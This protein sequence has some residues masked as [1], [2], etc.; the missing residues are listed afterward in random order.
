LFVFLSCIGISPFLASFLSLTSSF[1]STGDIILTKNL[2]ALIT[3]TPSLNSL[4]K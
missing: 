1:S 3:E 2:L 4:S